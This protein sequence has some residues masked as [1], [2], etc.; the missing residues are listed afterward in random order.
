MLFH[1][2]LLLKLLDFCCYQVDSEQ[3]KENISIENM[4]R[5]KQIRS[6]KSRTLTGGEFPKKQ[7][8][9]E[10]KIRVMEEKKLRKEV[11]VVL[12]MAFLYLFSD[13]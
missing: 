7:L 3:E 5:K 13:E 12:Y 6:C 4:G 8:S 9:R 2:L 10:E 11:S 1:L